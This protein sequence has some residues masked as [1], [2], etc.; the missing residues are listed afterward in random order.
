MGGVYTELIECYDG[1]TF[2]L[3][4]TFIERLKTD[5]DKR[6]YAGA[7]RLFHEITGSDPLH[8][9]E[10]TFARYVR[11]LNKRTEPNGEEKTWK[12]S[13]ALKNRKI[14]N[15]FVRYCEKLKH[16]GSVKVPADFEN[17][18]MY[19][20]MRAIQESFRY[21]DIVSVEDIDKLY[22]YLRDNKKHQLMC[23]LIFALRC[24]LRPVNFISA[25]FSDIYIDKTGEYF[26]NGKGRSMMVHIPSDCVPFFEAYAKSVH[27]NYIFSKTRTNE[28]M[29][30]DYLD[31]RLKKA[32][33]DAGITSNGITFNN[34]RNSATV[35]AVSNGATPEMMAEALDLQ[36]TAHFTKLSSLTLHFNYTQDYVGITFKAPVENE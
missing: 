17:K 19:S 11:A 32:C 30:I 36:T 21:K 15:S 9:T 25:T 8:A 35:Y 3:M 18:L 16:K 31:G 10:S 29:S 20:P 2:E 4:E 7:L 12:H 34:L 22:C 28:P 26:F 14:I 24:F 13:T 33:T 6:T 5:A 27:G 23:A 1:D